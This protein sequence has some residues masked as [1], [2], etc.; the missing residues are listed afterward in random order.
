MARQKVRIKLRELTK[1]FNVKE[2]QKQ[3]P[4]V[5]ILQKLQMD[6]AFSIRQGKFE[7]DIN[8]LEI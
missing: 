8:R 2:K 6:I 7:I 5:S 1:V 3:E 4:G